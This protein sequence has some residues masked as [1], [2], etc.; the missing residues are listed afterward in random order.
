LR[1]PLHEFALLHSCANAAVQHVRCSFIERD[2][3]AHVA[4]MR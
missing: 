1:D 2:N 3:F 4:W